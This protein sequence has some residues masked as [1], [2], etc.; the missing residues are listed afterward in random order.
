VKVSLVRV[1]QSGL[2]TAEARR[3][4]VHVAPSR[5]LHQRQVEDGR[6]DVTDCV[7]PCYL[8]FTVFNILDTKGIVVI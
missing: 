7:G 5:R 1:S 3:Q 8:T 6:V 2:K 4:V